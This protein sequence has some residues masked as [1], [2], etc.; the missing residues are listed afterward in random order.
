MQ[1]VTDS[2]QRLFNTHAPG[3]GWLRNTGLKLTERS[4][5][6]KQLLIEHAL[7]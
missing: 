3:L 1:L 4:S 2:L 7:G 5:P 6:L